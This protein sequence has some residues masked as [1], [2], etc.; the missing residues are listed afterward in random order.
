[1]DNQHQDVADPIAE[2][3]PIPASDDARWLRDLTDRLRNLAGERSYRDIGRRT[4]THPE[5][6]RRYLNGSPPC[7]RFIAAMCI[8]FDGS[9]DWVLTGRTSTNDPPPAPPP[10]TPLRAQSRLAPASAPLRAARPIAAQEQP[11]H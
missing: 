7:A 5:T 9:A 4:R 6:V 1:V 11:L 8:A 2:P 10:P 3:K